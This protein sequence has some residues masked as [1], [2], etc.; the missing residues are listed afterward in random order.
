MEAD[1]IG[2]IFV[3]SFNIQDNLRLLFA[4]RSPKDD[5]EMEVFN[6]VRCIAIAFIVLGQTV[7]YLL[8]GPLENAEITQRWMLDPRFL[9][10]LS[11]DLFVDVFFWLSAF[12]S[13]YFLLKK[14]ILNDGNMGSYAGIVFD[15]YIRLIPL[16][17]FT[18][19]FFWRFMILMGG[20]GPLFF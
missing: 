8:R 5:R 18:L 12:L 10:V 17:G 20:Q 15:R 14:M 13:S 2:Q 16:Y 9:F 11:A 3:R 19:L 7:F 4:F 6:G 1:N